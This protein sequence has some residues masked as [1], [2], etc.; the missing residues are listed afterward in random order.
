MYSTFIGKHTAEYSYCMGVSVFGSSK[1]LLIVIGS[2]LADLYTY[3]Y[4]LCCVF[5]TQL[6][7]LLSPGLSA[8]AII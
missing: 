1:T 3:S 6:S 4:C 8:V 2:I 5:F 7:L